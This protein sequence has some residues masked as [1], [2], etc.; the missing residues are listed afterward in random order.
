MLQFKI[1]FC[2]ERDGIVDLFLIIYYRKVCDLWPFR[3]YRSHINIHHK[4]RHVKLLLLRKF[5]ENNSSHP[6]H[7]RYLLAEI[8]GKGMTIGIACCLLELSS[9]GSEISSSHLVLISPLLHS[10][11]GMTFD[12]LKNLALLTSAVDSVRYCQ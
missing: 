4:Y 8:V 3:A 6:G 9:S 7:H 1:C 5:A 10:F 2:H 12:G 11:I